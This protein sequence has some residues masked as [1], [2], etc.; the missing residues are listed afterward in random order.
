MSACAMR[1]VQVPQTRKQCPPPKSISKTTAPPFGLRTVLTARQLASSRREFGSTTM[2]PAR[3]LEECVPV[4]DLY[5]S[6]IPG[7]A[8]RYDLSME[9]CNGY[10]PSSRD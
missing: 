8:G 10:S 2:T 9:Q 4:P 6:Q 3:E 7:A 1:T 5:V